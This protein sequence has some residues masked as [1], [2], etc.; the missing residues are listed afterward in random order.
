M[1]RAGHNALPTLEALQ[2]RMA[3]RRASKQLC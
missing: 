3:K 1:G 2:A